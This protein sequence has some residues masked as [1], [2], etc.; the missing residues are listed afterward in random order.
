MIVPVFQLVGLG[1]HQNVDDDDSSSGGGKSWISIYV[2]LFNN[3]IKLHWRVVLETN[4]H[5]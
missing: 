2:S 1:V 3:K 4:K 5:V